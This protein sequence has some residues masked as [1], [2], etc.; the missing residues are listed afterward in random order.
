M[1]ALFGLGLAL[2]AGAAMIPSASSAPAAGAG[3]AARAAMSTS[4]TTADG[5]AISSGGTA[6][7]AAL[8]AVPR[9]AAQAPGEIIEK[10]AGAR[11]RAS[12]VR[13]LLVG[14]LWRDVWTAPVQAPVLDPAEFPGGLRP[15]R[16]GG[17]AQTVTLH[18]LDGDGRGWLFRSTDKLADPKIPNDVRGTVFQTLLRDH[19]ASLHPG[20]PFMVPP[21]LEAVGVL[22]VRP[23]LI[24]MPDDST[25]GEHRGTFA[26]MLGGLELK[27]SEGDDGAAGFAGS[28]D[29]VDTDGL[30]ERLR[31]DPA[32]RLDERAYLRARLVDF[33]IGDP[34]RG[35][36]Q[37]R[38]AR[39][40]TGGEYLWEPIPRDRDWAFSNSDGLFGVVAR[41]IYP[42]VVRFGPDYPSIEALTYSSH[43][44]DRRSLTRLTRGDFMETAAAVRAALTDDVIAR[45]IAAMPPEWAA[46]SEAELGAALRARRDR[47]EYVAS[48][49]YAWL[50]AEAEVHGTDA[51][52][53][54]V[55]ERRA[56]GT[57]RVRLWPRPPPGHARHAAPDAY[58]PHYERVFLPGETREVRVYLHGGEDLARVT[59]VADGPITVRV[60]GGA[61]ADRLEDRAG[62][63]RLYDDDVDSTVF[64]RADGTRVDTRPWAEQRV[65]EGLRLGRHWAPDHG[66]E[67][68]FMPVLDQRDR[69]GLVVG[70]EAAFQRYGFRRY[71]YES[72][73]AL[74]G[75]VAPGTLGVGA[76]LGYDHRFKNSNRGLRFDAGAGRLD[77]F[78][79]HGFGND[80]PAL[81]PD[82][83]R[84]RF[85][86]V[87]LA[88]ALHGELGPR[89]RRHGVYSVGPAFAWTSP[90]AASSASDL[91]PAAD[92][93]PR[94]GARAMLALYRTDRPAA[95]RRGF[96]VRALAGGYPLVGAA[97][98]PYARM[99]AQAAA[100]VPL[101]RATPHLAVRLVGER[102][103][104]EFPVIDA[105]FLGGRN[106]LRGYDR[107]RFAGDGLLAGSAE[108][109]VPVDSVKLLTRG[110]LGVFVFTDTGRVWYRGATPGGWHTG[111]GG[112]AWFATLGRAVSVA[113]ARGEGTHV[114]AWLGLPF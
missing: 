42:K 41:R 23:R 29:I 86:A 72:R 89:D 13:R 28:R 114:H 47:I 81:D 62:R 36:D 84:Y 80:S 46:R 30:L 34:D 92:A 91:D 45:S 71:P 112:G 75:L 87:D 51:P 99:A 38:W 82:D 11:Y 100:Y 48:E 6:L 20:A 10:P 110:E 17:R 88:G 63:A 105:A 27:P 101:G 35:S 102:V 77:S 39:F 33:L 97:A 94:F 12:T 104:G 61:G 60:I 15:E 79:F 7:P 54:A 103:L 111:W 52:E 76:G 56:D 3:Q 19:V 53:I 9:A 73:L 68:S 44:L 25:F 59:G 70:A 4:T 55:I 8:A 18:M 93:V 85:V 16:R 21:L 95:P 37:W 83:A 74:R 32:H 58:T 1:S 26:G 113:V 107:G 5:R 90:R 96:R 22:H 65:P 24:V 109:R 64:I 78:R 31:G 66:G 50:S 106:S 69:S 2:A 49:F 40:G 108:L 43:A 98:G 14:G 67:R 57:V